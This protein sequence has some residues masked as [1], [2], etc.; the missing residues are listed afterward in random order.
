V[1]ADAEPSLPQ[2]ATAVHAL[3]G[4]TPSLLALAQLDDIMLEED[5]VNTPSTQ[6]YPNWRRRL[7][8]SLEAFGADPLWRA[9][10]DALGAERGPAARAAGR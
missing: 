6:R 7:A 8:A 1:S 2:L 4:R 3:L 9:V 5:P 10:A